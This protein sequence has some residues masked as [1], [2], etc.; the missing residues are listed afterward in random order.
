MREP[1]LFGDTSPQKSSVD[2]YPT[3]LPVVMGFL[4]N[5][6]MPDIF[7]RILDPGAGS[8]NISRVLRMNG[9]Q[10][11]IDAVELREEERK[12]LSGI[13][14]KPPNVYIENFLDF[15]PPSRYDLAIANPPFSLAEEF[16]EKCFS[17]SNKTALLLRLG[18]LCTEGRRA[19]WKKY[20][21]DSIYY[22]TNRP[23]FTGTGND[24]TEY[25][26]YVWGGPP[27]RFWI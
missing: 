23:S 9:W 21:Y 8:G 26:W 12:A 4:S 27:G 13:P 19:F 5:L 11:I 1:D 22:L 17:C 24:M 15:D 14:P 25:A 3:P 2:F 18:F 10:G 20:P 7:G 16:A 6:K